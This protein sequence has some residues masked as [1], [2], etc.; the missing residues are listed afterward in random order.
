MM[1][2]VT[3]FEIPAT[4]PQKSMAF[5]K[6][7]L[8][9]EFTRWGD[10]NYWLT[11]TGSDELPG[12]NGAVMKRKDPAQPVVTTAEVANLEETIQA[13]EKNGGQV[14]VPKMPIPTVGWLVYFK[15]PDGMIMGAIEPDE[16][17][18]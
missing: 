17:A 12:I 13:I 9:W 16:N 18:Q 4:D 3:H 6:A 11:T 2:R 15:D 5:Y 14:V 1:A 7:V 10:E 8:G